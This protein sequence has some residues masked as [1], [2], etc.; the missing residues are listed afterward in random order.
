MFS[1]KDRSMRGYPIQEAF[2]IRDSV[3]GF[4]NASWRKWILCDQKVSNEKMGA[5]GCLGYMSGMKYYAVMWG[6]YKKPLYGS[7]H[8]TTSISWKVMP[9]FFSWLFCDFNHAVPKA[10]ASKNR[11]LMT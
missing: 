4:S 1:G 8:Q 11:Y 9:F 2:H 10:A 7:G 5:P 3:L 6:L